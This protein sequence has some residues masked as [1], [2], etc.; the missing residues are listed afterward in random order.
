[1]HARVGKRRTRF[2][3]T[4]SDFLF[5]SMEP[6]IQAIK[7]AL[8]ELLDIPPSALTLYYYHYKVNSEP[9]CLVEMYLEIEVGLRKGRRCLDLLQSHRLELSQQLISR[10]S[11]EIFIEISPIIY[12]R[13]DS[14]VVI[15]LILTIV[16]I[17]FILLSIFVIHAKKVIQERNEN[18]FL[19]C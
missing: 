2:S 1:M 4:A 13:R 10:V 5:D 11:G 3:I 12:S 18:Y 9:F 6:T 8:P 17:C 14:T 19:M 16:S 15:A 7:E